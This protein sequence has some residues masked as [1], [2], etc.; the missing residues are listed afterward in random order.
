MPKL[1]ITILRNGKKPGKYIDSSRTGLFLHIRKN[2]NKQWAQ[3]I[4]IDGK[5]TDLGL[6][7]CHAGSLEEAMADLSQARDRAEKNQE[8]ARSGKNPT[9]TQQKT[10]QKHT[11]EE[12]ARKRHKEL[13]P[14]FTNKKGGKQW[15]SSLEAYA[16]PHIGRMPVKNVGPGDIIDLLLENNFWQE[17]PE[18]ARRVFQRIRNVMRYACVRRYREDDPTTDITMVMP[19]QGHRPVPQK[20]LPYQEVPA[21]MGMIRAKPGVASLGLLFQIYTAARP[22]EVRHACWHEIDLDEKLWVVPAEKMK[23]RR[24]HA[25]PLSDQA[26]LILREAR[27]QYAQSAS[28]G[29][30]EL[31]FPNDRSGEALS[32]MAFTKVTKDLKL[33]AVPHGFRSSFRTWVQEQTNVPREVAEAALAHVNRDRVEAVYA[34]SDFL[35]KRRSLMQEWAD[36]ISS[37]HD[38]G[39]LP[40]ARRG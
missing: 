2:G 38:E 1:N 29:S 13:M 16:F 10:R 8:A 9:S 26:V 14:S 21:A 32:D 37:T 23:M 18:L 30:R 28:S 33:A 4:T 17:K 22:G 7:R 6:G 27:M 12:V 24:E 31:V 11:F 15:L 5:R 36:F 40:F 20:S 34:R 39:V 19:K 35:E 3:R 25:V